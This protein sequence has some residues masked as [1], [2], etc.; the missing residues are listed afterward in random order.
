MKGSLLSIS[1]QR[2]CLLGASATLVTMTS[3]SNPA[4]TPGRASSSPGAV[5]AI[6]TEDLQVA[7]R[8]LNRRTT[9]DFAAELYTGT[10]S[11][12]N[13]SRISDAAAA[14]AQAA[15]RLPETVTGAQV[16]DQ[17]RIEFTTLANQM[18]EQAT[19]LKSAADANDVPRLRTTMDRLNATCTACHSRFRPKAGT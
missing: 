5:H 14:V 13:L 19:Q 4:E 1:V 6:H 16:S 9:E 12:G 17:D 10:P 3:C 11:S 7:M 2:F 15:R 8:S 18:H